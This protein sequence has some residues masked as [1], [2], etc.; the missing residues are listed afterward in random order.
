M[1]SSW[2]FP[3]E[4]VVPVTVA[5]GLVILVRVI[6]QKDLARKLNEKLKERKQ[7]DK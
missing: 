7:A 2:T 4:Y 3:S 1:I 5:F 6:R